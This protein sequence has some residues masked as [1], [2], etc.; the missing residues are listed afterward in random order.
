MAI[1]VPI[2]QVEGKINS[3]GR[4]HVS[5]FMEVLFRWGIEFDCAGTRGSEETVIL[6]S[7]PI[8]D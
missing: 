7:V 6:V 2:R 1:R 4:D 5:Q 3:D 8:V